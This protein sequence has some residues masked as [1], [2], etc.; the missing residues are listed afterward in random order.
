MQV[1]R[2]HSTL[3]YWHIN[4]SDGILNYWIC[5][6]VAFLFALTEFWTVVVKFLLC[7]GLWLSS[8]F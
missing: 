2:V 6:L 4:Q 7:E 3:S 1:A 5:V 8:L